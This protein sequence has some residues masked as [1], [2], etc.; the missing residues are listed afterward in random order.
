METSRS[1]FTPRLP[2]VS[3]ARLMPRARYRREFPEKP[4]YTRPAP[5][6]ASP[7]PARERRRRPKASIPAPRVIEAMRSPS[8]TFIVRA[9]SVCADC[10]NCMTSSSERPEVALGLGGSSDAGVNRKERAANP[11]PDK[12]REGGRI[13]NRIGTGESNREGCTESLRTG[14]LGSDLRS[15]LLEHGH[16]TS[17][18]LPFRLVEGEPGSPIDLGEILEAPGA[19]RPFE[20]EGVAADGRGVAVALEGPGCHYLAARLLDRRQGDE[21]AARLD[22]CLL[23]ELARGGDEPLLAGVVLSLGNRP[24][25]EVLVLPEWAARVDEQHFQLAS[26]PTEHE[27]APALLRHVAILPTNLRRAIAAGSL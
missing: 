13:A 8:P 10:P 19:A 23:P 25:A 21:G 14:K 24:G 17:E 11:R 12:R 26:V 6:R 15:Q 4:R 22:P 5:V 1:T 16:L 18:D 9:V 2:R 3:P 7:Q 27:Q 20:R